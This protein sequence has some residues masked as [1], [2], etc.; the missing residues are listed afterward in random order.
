MIRIDHLDIQDWLLIW[1]VRLTWGSVKGRLASG[2]LLHR[3]LLILLLRL[4]LVVLLTVL[5]GVTWLYRVNKSKWTT[6]TLHIAL[7]YGDTCL[8][9]LPKQPR[10]SLVYLSVCIHHHLS[11]SFSTSPYP[12]HATRSYRTERYERNHARNKTGSNRRDSSKM[13]NLGVPIKLLHESLGHII[14]VELKTGEVSFLTYF[15]I[16]EKLM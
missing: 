2:K 6:S 13:A 7:C 12:T 9:P 5:K 14:T 16:R 15:M 8:L 4:D 3:R 10:Y 1:F 11:I